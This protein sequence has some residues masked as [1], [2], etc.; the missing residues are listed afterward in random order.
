MSEYYDGTKLLS[1]KDMNGNDPEI[2]L[3]VGNRS[4]GKTTYFN[5]L[6]INSFIKRK[7]KFCIVYRF[8]YELTDCVDKFFKDIHTLFFP[9]YELN[10]VRKAH[11]MFYELFLNDEACGYAICLNQADQIKKLSHFFSDVS[12][13]LFDEFQSE[14][15][16]YCADEVTKFVSIHMSIARGGGQHVRRVPVYM[17]SNA[18]TLLNP[19]YVEM[20]ISGRLKGDTKFL[21]GDGWVL[22]QSYLESVA[23]AQKMSGFNRAFKKNSYVGYAT[24]NIYLNDNVTFIE[25]PSGGGRY[26]VTLRYKGKDFAVRK[27]SDLGIVYC[28]DRVDKSFPYKISVTTDDMQIN[29]VNLKENDILVSDLR[30]YFN[31]GCFRF[32]D[33]MC[34]EVIL[35][36]LSYK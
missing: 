9:Q 22:E 18:V 28:D 14:T 24:E 36:T 25:K 1:M 34:K 12:R 30:Y 11:G 29:Y 35:K 19:Y 2:Y 6:C 32:K 10:G 4:S 27:F 13:M 33:L 21:K 5:R 23:E 8:A 16:K 26:A 7:E 31:H 20:D 15:N 17:L 3:A